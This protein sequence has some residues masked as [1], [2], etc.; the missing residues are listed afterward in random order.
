MV[1]GDIP[2]SQIAEQGE[3]RLTLVSKGHGAM[4]WIVLFNQHMPIEAVHLRNG[5]DAYAAEGAWLSGEYLPC[6]T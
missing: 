5:E 2:N 1:I 4:V 3:Q 6:A